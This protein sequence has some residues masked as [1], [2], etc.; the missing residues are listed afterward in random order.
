MKKWNHILHIN[1]IDYVM[2]NKQVS[3]KNVLVD[4]FIFFKVF[5][6]LQIVSPDCFV[7]SKT[8]F[9]ALIKIIPVNIKYIIK[10]FTY[11]IKNQ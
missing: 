9:K 1:I 4:F 3:E 7:K 10:N 6:T 11:H 2:N 5:I 8:I